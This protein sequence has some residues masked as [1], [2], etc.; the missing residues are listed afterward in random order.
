MTAE[1]S[2]MTAMDAVAFLPLLAG[3]VALV[4]WAWWMIR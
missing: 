2:D 1:I 3:L 4:G